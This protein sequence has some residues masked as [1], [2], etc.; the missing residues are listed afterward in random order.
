MS[1]SLSLPLSPPII[2]QPEAGYDITPPVSP[3]K[4]DD[5]EWKAAHPVRAQHWQMVNDLE[6][7]GV[8]VNH[9]T[10]EELDRLS[11]QGHERELEEALER[12]FPT[13]EE[14]KEERRRQAASQREEEWPI[15]HSSRKR[16][17]EWELEHARK[18]YEMTKQI[19]ALYQEKQGKQCKAMQEIMQAAKRHLDRV[20]LS[21][22]RP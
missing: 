22:S 21:S 9:M 2:S 14:E 1:L 15:G 12:R 6:E 16:K 13:E 11:Q 7:Q 10:D 19:C 17:D 18:L 20:A 3:S 8:L 4:D 5:A